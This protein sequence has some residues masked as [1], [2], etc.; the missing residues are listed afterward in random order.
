MNGQILLLLKATDIKKYSGPFPQ[1]IP[2]LG[3]FDELEKFETPVCSSAIASYRRTVAKDIESHQPNKSL[4]HMGLRLGLGLAIEASLSSLRSPPN[5]TTQSIEFALIRDFAETQ[6]KYPNIPQSSLQSTISLLKTSYSLKHSYLS[7]K[8]ANRVLVKSARYSGQKLDSETVELID[9]TL[10]RYFSETKVE[11]ATAFSNSVLSRGY[12]MLPGLS[13]ETMI[14]RVDDAVN[15]AHSF[16]ARTS[17]EG[18][19]KKELLFTT[20]LTL[21]KTHRRVGA[22]D[23]AE[24]SLVTLT[25]IDEHEPIAWSELGLHYHFLCDYKK[26]LVCFKRAIALGP[27]S[28]ALNSYFAGAAQFKLLNF[29]EGIKLMIQSIRFDSFALSPRLDL[30]EHYLSKNQTNNARILSDEILGTNEL[31]TQL[32]EKERADLINLARNT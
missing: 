5:P 30:I 19:L 23:L 1:R 2:R 12:A 26:S 24:K 28:L 21:A 11:N 9:N 3:F 13:N 29:E 7:A 27:P 22:I 31:V 17:L 6:I 15:F 25:E 8:I 18:A 10:K 14:K 20:L 16:Q 4:Y 32:N